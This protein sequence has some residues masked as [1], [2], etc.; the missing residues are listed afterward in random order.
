MTQEIVTARSPFV[1]VV[2]CPRSGT[3]LLQRMLDNHPDLAVANDSHFIPLAVRDVPV[4][5][6]PPLTAELVEWVRTYRRFYRLGLTDEQV[7][8]AATCATTYA[9]FVGALYSTYARVRG[10][11]LGG[12]KTP[13]YVKRLPR[14]HGLFPGARYI[15]IIRD[16]RDVALSA[17][18]W[19][20][21]GKGPGKLALWDDEPVAVCALWWSSMVVLGRRDGAALGPAVYREVGYERLVD[22]PKSQLAE[23][24][25][26][27]DVPDSPSMA[28]FH[29]G[30]TRPATGRS[31]KS[32][33]L[34]ATSGLRSWQSAMPPRELSLFE[35]LAGDLLA[36]VGYELS[37]IPASAEVAKVARAAREWW[38]DGVGHR[39]SGEGQSSTSWEGSSP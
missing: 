35:A 19:A 37:G 27:L 29:E 28:N 31:A 3:T 23:L 38:D 6:D 12:E 14:L 8:E 7:D 4:G 10:K 26:F 32:A 33:W 5:V 9:G 34:P 11:R 25:A 39:W 20:T 18:E 15:H 1:F 24:A 16:G 13:D 22:D 2:G 21:E 17:L 36:E 30:R